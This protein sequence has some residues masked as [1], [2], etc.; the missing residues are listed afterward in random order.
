MPASADAER[1][2]AVLLWSQT[3]KCDCEACRYFR[4]LARELVNKH[5]K[6]GVAV[7]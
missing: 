7:G 4:S 2:M 3:S 5:I 6:G 1:F